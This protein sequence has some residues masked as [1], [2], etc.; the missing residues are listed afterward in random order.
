MLVPRMPI[1]THPDSKA[2]RTR[3]TN[4]L[5]AGLPWARLWT[6]FGAGAR[7]R[8]RTGMAASAAEGLPIA[9]LH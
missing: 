9:I 1:G 7:G 8:A 3:Q 5:I 2:E 4:V 6:L